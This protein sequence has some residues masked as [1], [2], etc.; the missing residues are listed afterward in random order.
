MTKITDQLNHSESHAGNLLY[1]DSIMEG[2]QYTGFAR[3]LKVLES[4]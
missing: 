4:P 3:A 2:Y 1:W